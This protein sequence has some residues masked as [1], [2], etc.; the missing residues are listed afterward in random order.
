MPD[1]I[2]I[3]AGA[4]GLSAARALTSRGKS[5]LL[6]EARERLGGRIHTIRD[7]NLNFPIELGAEFIHGVPA[8]TWQIIRAAG[9]P[10]CDLNG[11]EFQFIDNRLREIKD[12]FGEIEPVMQRLKKARKGQSFASVIGVPKTPAEHLAYSYIEGFDAAPPDRASAIA[13]RDAEKDSEKIEG[14]RQFRLLGGYDAVVGYLHSGCDP[15]KLTIRLN[16]PV[17]QIEWSKSGVKVHA[18][19]E[20]FTAPR[21]IVTVPLA[22]L[23]GNDL[24]FT[25][26]IPEKRKIANRLGVSPVVKITL[27]FRQPFWEED[28]KL[29]DFL[30]LLSRNMV[31]PTWWTLMPLRSTVLTGWAGGPAAEKLSGNSREEILSVALETLCQMTGIKLQTIRENLSASHVTDWQSDPW[32]RGAYSYIPVGGENAVEEL[33]KPVANVIFFAGE[34]THTGGQSGTVPGAIASGHRAADEVL[35]GKSE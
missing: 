14:E 1:V 33:A 21:L 34:A 29:R 24:A 26:D 20:H 5:V 31:V 27:I 6:L 8:E 17:R 23:Q 9:I 4:A 30:F 16:T 35:R 7:S 10:V 28:E 12:L 2:I 18:R 15:N 19:G 32:S 22:I 25:P 11:K 3:G 13:I